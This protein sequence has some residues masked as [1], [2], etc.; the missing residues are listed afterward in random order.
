MSDERASR[1]LAAIFAGDIA[2]YSRLMGVDEEG[3]LVQL[4]QHRK[5]LV[6][7]KILE[8]RGR[9]VK[10]TGDGMLV[11]FSSAVDAVRCAVEIQ[12][13]MAERNQRIPQD[14][15]IEFRIGINV[16][17]IIFGDGDIFGDGV[18][19]AARLEGLAS[20]GGIMVSRTVHD[21]VRDKLSFIF[22]DIGEQSVKNIA[23][24]VQAFRIGVGDGTR[25]A[26]PGVDAV[27]KRPA[28]AV[29]PFANLTNDP[30]QEYFADGLTED[31]ITA[32]SCWRLF[33]VIARNSTFVYK[34]RAVKVQQVAQELN[35]KYVIEGSVRKGGDRVRVSVQLIDS[36]TGHHLWAERYDR[37]LDDIF[38]LQDEITQRIV[39]VV[40]P[41]M[42]RVE[43]QRA[44][45][46]PPSDLYAWDFY[47]RG[48]SHL[49]EFSKAG[50]QAARQMF[51][52]GAALDPSY[53]RA[54]TGIAY[55]HYRDVLLTHSDDAERSLA[56]AIASA[57]QA[58]SLD[59]TDGFAH[60]VLSRCLLHDGKPDE[61]LNEAGQ[62]V[63]LNPNDSASH[64]SM[65]G[66]LVALGRPEEGIAAVDR[67]LQLSPKDI[68]IYLYQIVKSSGL[69]A[70]GRYAEAANL[71]AEV[72]SRR[73]NDEMA[74]ALLTA[75][76][77]LS[78]DI[79]RARANLAAAER[80]AS[81]LN[82]PRGIINWLGVKDR[83]RLKEGL[84]LV[85][86][87]G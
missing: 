57:R 36:E 62:A 54:Y 22:E 55:S 26:E 83:E 32:L 24:P 21:Q 51:E 63:E 64:A 31:I 7:P 29:L 48:M 71:T 85:G 1:R 2:G 46:K 70:A 58:I 80:I 28:I 43:R 41:E 11:E 72:L 74:R 84:R 61:A 75:S 38:A 50:N 47:L 76:F 44:L 5:Q 3:T 37:K 78:G 81:V 9:I 25:A 19:V 17:D 82:E 56:S 4:K 35:A 14:K 20:A 18:N 34:G 59:E 23:R 77:A 66:I 79:E 86:W 53:S 42:E 68:R 40:A 67:A 87:A 27:L 39:G 69:F 30:E 16:G 33:P 12:K 73:P 52:R 49:H 15:R 45:S 6:D 65:G 60:F 10:T 13:G 8:H